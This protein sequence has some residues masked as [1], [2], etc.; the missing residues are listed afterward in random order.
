M[1]AS[2][3][4]LILATALVAAPALADPGDAVW[5][6]PNGSCTATIAYEQET[7]NYRVSSGAA[8]VW[9]K[10]DIKIDNTVYEEKFSGGST[11]GQVTRF[12]KDRQV[13]A[14]VAGC[15]T[16]PTR[17]DVASGCF[18]KYQPQIVA[19]CNSGASYRTQDER[20]AL[21]RGRA[22]TQRY[23][24]RIN[25]CAG[26]PVVAITGGSDSFRLQMDRSWAN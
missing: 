25:A 23:V 19:E 14:S 2:R 18:F 26:A 3:N 13:R 24:D 7:G 9:K 4:L 15:R 12:H 5:S 6:R 16:Y 22:C 21:E 17:N 1:R 10:V 8:G 11:T 20:S